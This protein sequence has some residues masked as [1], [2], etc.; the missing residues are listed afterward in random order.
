MQKYFTLFTFAFLSL[1][2]SAQ[3]YDILNYSVVKILVHTEGRLSFYT[4]FSWK[5]SRHIV[6]TLHAIKSGSSI[7][8]LFND[9][10]PKSAHVLKTYKEADLVMLKVD[11]EPP[12]GS[13]FLDKISFQLPESGE[14]FKTKVYGEQLIFSSFRFL[15]LTDTLSLNNKMPLKSDKS[16]A[17]KATPQVYLVKESWLPGFS[18]A[19][20]VDENGNLFGIYCGANE[21]G[22][23]NHSW[24]IPA[25]NV[26]LL[27]NSTVIELPDID[28][29][30][31][32]FY[33][34]EANYPHIDT[35]ENFEIDGIKEIENE[36]ANHYKTFEINNFKFY[37][38]KTRSF[39]ELVNSKKSKIALSH[40]L[41]FFQKYQDFLNPMR[42]DIY[43]EINNGLILVL[44]EN[45]YFQKSISCEDFDYSLNIVSDNKKCFTLTV[46][47][48]EDI[49]T[50]LTD[51]VFLENMQDFAETY[52][53]KVKLSDTLHVLEYLERFKYVENFSFDKE[54]QED[55]LIRS[56]SLSVFE[57][58]NNKIISK[59]I[60]K[61]ISAYNEDKTYKAFLNTNFVFDEYLISLNTLIDFNKFEF[62][63]KKDFECQNQNELSKECKDLQEVAS[64]MLSVY[65]S[66]LR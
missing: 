36:L 30:Y 62:F 35:T 40:F 4:G 53:D 58:N 42:F 66:D 16:S 54:D 5:N 17:F 50:S 13:E 43:E 9:E 39:S 57:N 60:Y 45:T 52:G 44:P 64:F 15:T 25:K 20:V 65:L 37:K 3:N 34:S 56:D 33:S 6:T 31:A 61:L 29:K 2:L 26:L 47:W 18:G 55:L 11:S 1:T 14:K 38:T 21:E 24:L 59:N 41:S 51:E 32:H 23:L 28:S 12:T 8:V 49:K 63:G 10:F 48:L 19:P 22:I 7:T 46:N 27:E